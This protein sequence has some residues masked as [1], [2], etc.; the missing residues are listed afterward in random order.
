MR[1]KELSCHG[2]IFYQVCR[3]TGTKIYV[4]EQTPGRPSM[5]RHVIVWKGVDLQEANSSDEPGQ[6]T[7]ESEESRSSCLQGTVPRPAVYITFHSL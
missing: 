6:G 7:E 5:D 3:F 1:T 2:G 4:P